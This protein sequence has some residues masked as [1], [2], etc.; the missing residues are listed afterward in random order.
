MEVE[1]VSYVG[2]WEL[3]ELAE[4]SWDTRLWEWGEARGQGAKPEEEI[5]LAFWLGEASFLKLV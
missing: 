1:W 4:L 3:M 5:Y 2:L